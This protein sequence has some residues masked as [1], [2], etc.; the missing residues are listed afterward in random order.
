MRTRRAF[1]ATASCLP[2]ALAV[3][4]VAA[5]DRASGTTIPQ[6]ESIQAERVIV[7]TAQRRAEA[8]V[9]V[10]ISITALDAGMLET[11]NV[12]ELSGIQS[13]VPA[14]RFD[15]QSQFVQPTIR[16]VGT[17][18]TTSGGGSNVGIYVDGFYS[19]NPA[20]ADFDLL[21]VRSVQVLKGPQGTLFG[22]NTTGGAILVETADPSVDPA[23]EFRAS[24]A[25]FE[26]IRA[27]GYV[28]TG[29]TDS[30]ALDLEVNYA[31]GKAY[32]RNI[33]SGARDRRY[34]NWQV[35]TGLKLDLGDVTAKLRYQHVETDDPRPL[36]YNIFVDDVLGVGAPSFAPPS[37]YTTDPDF[38][39]PGP[40][41]SF[42]TTNNDIVQLTLEADLGFADLAS[43]TQYRDQDVDA[44]LDLDKTALTIFQYGLPVF[45]RTFTQEFLLTSKPGPALQYTAGLFYLFNSDRYKTYADN[46][47]PLGFGRVRLGGSDAPTRSYAAFVDLTY[48]VTPSLFVTG[49]L[50]YAHDTITNA[51]YNV[52]EEA[53]DVADVKSD[54]FTPR[55]VV[56]YK[57]S[58]TTSI[59]ASYAR[60]YK[61]AIL[62][63]GGSCQNP[64]DFVCNDVSPENIDAFEIGFKTESELLSFEAAAFY[65]DYRNLQVSL[66]TDGRAEIINAAKAEVYG[67]EAALALRLGGG[68]SITAGGAYVHG[69]YT[70]F[71]GAPVYMPC[72]DFGPDVAAS[73]AGSGVSYLNVPVDL[74]NVDMQ[75]TPEFTGN[76]GARWEVGLAGGE[77]ALSGNFYYTSSF[78]FGPSGTQFQGGDYE[79]LALRAQWDDPESRF[80]LAVFGD[81]VTDSRYVNQVQYNNFGFGATWS[82]PRTWGVEIGYRY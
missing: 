82:Q 81:N 42:I 28:T 68:F 35:R 76:L 14:L 23:M 45:N 47:V 38:Y 30:L 64:P 69:R 43:F 48:E 67:A 74:K 25:S 9:D 13:M 2:L 46:A 31:T 10:P 29:L 71:P 32:Q 7:V 66:F 58:D 77:L 54:R 62:D 20:E 60:G 75:R 49:G 80:F 59:Y 12:R 6:D 70:D 53:F 39:A 22:R 1:L 19:P 34:R 37:T 56:R 41:R 16:G 17:S 65:Y 78:F 61:A 40:D 15:R 8:Q 11:A 52:G 79:T 63:V 73:C 3:A 5:Q 36:L 57:P 55:L 44:S 50:R 33:A 72:A 4:P 27:Q 51:F 26:A 24:L 18:I 21:K